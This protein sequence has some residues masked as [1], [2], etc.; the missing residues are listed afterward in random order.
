[1][2]ARELIGVPTDQWFAKVSYQPSEVL[3]RGWD[4]L[5]LVVLIHCA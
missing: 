5:G 2:N 1:L 4:S 3:T